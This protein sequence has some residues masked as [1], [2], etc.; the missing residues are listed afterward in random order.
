MFSY[1]GDF[2]CIDCLPEGLTGEDL[3]PIDQDADLI[4]CVCGFEQETTHIE[5]DDD[6]QS[7]L[8]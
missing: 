2:Y 4:C 3:D 8:D 1:D 5:E 7:N 6:D